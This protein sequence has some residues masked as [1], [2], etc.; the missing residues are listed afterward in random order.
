[1]FSLKTEY[2]SMPKSADHKNTY[3]KAGFI[4]F[5]DHRMIY[6]LKSLNFHRAM[7]GVIWGNSI[8][9]SPPSEFTGRSNRKTDLC[10]IV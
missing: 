4:S 9:Q 10:M 5:A 8:P 6:D 1:M 2:S 7:D 3:G